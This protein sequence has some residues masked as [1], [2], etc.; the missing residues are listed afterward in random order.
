LWFSVDENEYV[1]TFDHSI[2]GVRNANYY[3]DDEVERITWPEYVIRTL[4][5]WTKKENEEQ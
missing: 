3:D 1:W 2:Q 4:K 5:R